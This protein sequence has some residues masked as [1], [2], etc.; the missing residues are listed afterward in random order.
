[1][2]AKFYIGILSALLLAGMPVKAQYSDDFY[3]Y[4]DDA[5]IIVNNY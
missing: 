2:K 5:R 3:P 1:M 4:N